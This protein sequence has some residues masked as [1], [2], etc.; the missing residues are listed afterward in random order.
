MTHYKAN[1][2]LSCNDAAP[3]GVT[4]RPGKLWGVKIVLHNGGG[5]G[6]S[7]MAVRLDPDTAMDIGLEIVALAR[8]LQKTAQLA[9]A[10]KTR[11]ANHRAGLRTVAEAT[12]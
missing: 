3:R 4:V 9:E 10:E 7:N 8:Q 5:G 12:Q 1:A 11:Q 6:G 2:H